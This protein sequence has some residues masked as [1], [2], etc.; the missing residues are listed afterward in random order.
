MAIVVDGVVGNGSFRGQ[1]AIRLP[2]PFQLPPI[3]GTYQ[4]QRLAHE[5]GAGA[6]DWGG[7]DEYTPIIKLV[8]VVLLEVGET[9]FLLRE[10]DAAQ[11]ANG[12]RDGARDGPAVAPTA[13][14]Q[15]SRDA[16]ETPP[17]PHPQPTHHSN[18]GIDVG[19]V[20]SG[21]AYSWS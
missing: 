19:P 18:G 11:D 7:R 9:N 16:D 8:D 21:L 10:Y 15:T 6:P 4:L 12:E 1:P 5:Q 3:D 13:T 2:P 14:T 17:P 20:I